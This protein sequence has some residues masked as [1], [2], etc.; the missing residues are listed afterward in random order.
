MY[1]FIPS[2]ETDIL[3]F[4]VV[5]PPVVVAVVLGF[6]FSFF[7]FFFFVWKLSCVAFRSLFPPLLVY[8]VV[9]LLCSV[10]TCLDDG[11]QN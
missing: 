4:T 3:I 1:N 6:F 10:M 7:G 8:L 9:L 11:R 5:C 2:M